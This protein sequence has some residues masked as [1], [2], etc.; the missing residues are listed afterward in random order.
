M[1]ALAFAA[2]VVAYSKKQLASTNTI[3]TGFIQ[4]SL[5]FAKLMDDFSNPKIYLL[6]D[7]FST[8]IKAVHEV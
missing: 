7:A 4:Y 2:I 5:E 8:F 1:F 3:K 6:G